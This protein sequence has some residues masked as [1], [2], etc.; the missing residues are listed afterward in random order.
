MGSIARPLPRRLGAGLA[1]LSEQR[2]Q[3]SG[4]TA[5]H[6]AE[7]RAAIARAAHDV[8]RDPD[9]VRRVAVSKP[10][11]AEG[12]L[13]ALEAGQRLFGENYVQESAAKWPALRERSPD[14]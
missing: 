5:T 8:G 12:I 6:L 9:S 14:T 4:D 7:V 3:A 13:P 2:M 11:A 1:R 10:G